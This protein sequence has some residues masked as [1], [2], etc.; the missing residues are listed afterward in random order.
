MPVHD[1]HVNQV[2][3]APFGGRDIAGEGG[4]VGGED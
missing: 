3:A 4:E 2:C 1:I